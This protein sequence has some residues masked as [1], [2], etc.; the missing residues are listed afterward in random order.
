VAER[1]GFEPP[2]PVKV[3]LISSQLH[4]TGLC[5]LSALLSHI[6]CV[7]CDS[8]SASPIIPKISLVSHC[9]STLL[10]FLS[11]AFPV[12]CIPGGR[13]ILP[14][15]RCSAAARVQRLYVRDLLE[16]RGLQAIVVPQRIFD[17]FRCERS[18]DCEAIVVGVQAVIREVAPHEAAGIH[19]G[20]EIVEIGDVGPLAVVLDPRVDL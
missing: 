19:Q 16:P 9:V 5:H 14:Q 7:T 20:I 18:H 3:W 10:H 6:E 11:A 17:G 15:E 8:L 13:C 1:E 12:C 4:S 2:I